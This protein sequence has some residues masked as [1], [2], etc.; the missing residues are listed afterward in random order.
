MRPHS[1]KKTAPFLLGLLVWWL[2]TLN[3]CNNNRTYH[4]NQAL[5]LFNLCIC[6]HWH[7]TTQQSFFYFESQ[8]KKI[9]LHNFLGLLICIQRRECLFNSPV[10][11]CFVC[12]SSSTLFIFLWACISLFPLYLHP[13]P[14]DGFSISGC[15]DWFLLW[16]PGRQ[17]A[18]RLLCSKNCFLPGLCDEL[19]AF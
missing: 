19:L 5:L 18:S 17:T 1:H 8:P 15:G 10:Q 11:G 2:W 6:Q 14:L 12:M 13:T 3:K 16:T 7:N 9:G 4:Y